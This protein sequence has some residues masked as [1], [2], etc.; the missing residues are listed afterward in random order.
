M[1]V[2]DKESSL[3]QFFQ[4]SSIL[5]ETLRCSMIAK[6]NG[7][8]TMDGQFVPNISWYTHRIGGVRRATKSL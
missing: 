5:D 4:T 8:I 7:Y 3:L 2:K 6:L 1:L